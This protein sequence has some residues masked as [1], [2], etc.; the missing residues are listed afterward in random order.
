M[1]DCSKINGLRY[2]F[3]MP[4]SFTWNRTILLNRYNG[5]GNTSMTFQIEHDRILF[6]NHPIHQTD[7][8]TRSKHY[9]EKT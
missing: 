8:W 5:M 3:P 9:W 7:A 2:H 1:R 6:A 4:P